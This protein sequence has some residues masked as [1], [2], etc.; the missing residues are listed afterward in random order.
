[1]G[2]VGDPVAKEPSDLRGFL[3]GHQAEA[4]LGDGSRG[5]NRFVSRPGVP[6]ATPFKVK[7]GR[8]VVR[9]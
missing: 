7:A 2:K 5:D 4:Q 6:P 9:S 3:V 1:M 8:A